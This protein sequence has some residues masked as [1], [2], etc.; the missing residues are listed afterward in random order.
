MLV[1]WKWRRKR[2][3]LREKPLDVWSACPAY[4]AR[5]WSRTVRNICLGPRFSSYDR[6]DIRNRLVKSGD[7]KCRKRGC[8]GGKDNL[9]LDLVKQSLLAERID[10]KY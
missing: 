3:S 4:L 7:F 2:G 1:D 10:A 9:K 6:S 8:I 5:Y